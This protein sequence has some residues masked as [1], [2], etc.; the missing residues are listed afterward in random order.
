MGPEDLRR[1][2]VSSPAGFSAI[3]GFSLGNHRPIN[4]LPREERLQQT[5]ERVSNVRKATVPTALAF[6]ATMALA[7]V[8]VDRGYGR[9]SER[10]RD[11]RD[12]LGARITEEAMA[13]QDLAGIMQV[14]QGVADARGAVPDWHGIFKELGAL[15]PDQ[16]QLESLRFERSGAALRLHLDARV[17]SRSPSFERVLLDLNASPFFTDVRLL[18]ASLPSP[19]SSGRFEASLSILAR[20]EHP[21]TTQP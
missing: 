4:L 9:T 19:G 21:L 2:D 6:G 7:A 5:L 8:P 20:S 18:D 16:F 15:L 12:S 1:E 11:T 3:L 17:H 14:A 10:M 13:A